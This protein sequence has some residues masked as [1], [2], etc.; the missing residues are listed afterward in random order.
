MGRVPRTKADARRAI[1]DSLETFYNQRR[2]HSSQNPIL[3]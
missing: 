1:F 2:R 3:N